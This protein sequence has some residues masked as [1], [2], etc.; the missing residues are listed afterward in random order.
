MVGNNYC[1]VVLREGKGKLSQ[2][3]VL[4]ADE[5]VTII[6]QHIAAYPVSQGTQIN[7]SAIVTNEQKAGTPFE[8]RWVSNVA[9][10]EVEEAYRDFEPAVQNIV[11]ASLWFPL[12]VSSLTISAQCMEHPSR[13]ALHVINDLPLST[14][15]RVAL[16]GD[17][18]RSSSL[19]WKIS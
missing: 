11:K 10:E 14:C 3:C 2:S 1:F 19:T 4:L 8:G 16:I 17:A 7:I 13:W 9:R 5:T 6:L 18:V 12:T 15:D